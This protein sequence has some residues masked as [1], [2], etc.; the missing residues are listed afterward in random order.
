MH[1]H[2]FEPRYSLLIRRVLASTDCTFGMIAAEPTPPGFGGTAYPRP[3]SAGVL[4]RVLDCRPLAQG[5]FLVSI[6]GV[7]R[8]RVVRTWEVDDYFVAQAAWLS[9]D[10]VF[11]RERRVEAEALGVE[12]GRML[13]E[14]AGEVRAEER[15]K[16]GEGGAEWAR[17]VGGVIGRAGWAGQ[18]DG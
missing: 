8:V 4:V 10:P 3:A 16:G 13:D 14:W 15:E 6:E 18:V 5:R 2:V 9:D 11:D 1:L 12:V 7:R 17:E